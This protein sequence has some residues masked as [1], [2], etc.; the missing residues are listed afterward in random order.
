VPRHQLWSD[1]LQSTSVRRALRLTQ[2]RVSVNSVIASGAAASRIRIVAAR[3]SNSLNAGRATRLLALTLVVSALPSCSG[4]TIDLYGSGT[5]KKL[6]WQRELHR[7][8]PLIS[9]GLGLE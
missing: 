5:H 1:D 2:P 4:A 8:W 3:L 9:R 6:Y 7:A